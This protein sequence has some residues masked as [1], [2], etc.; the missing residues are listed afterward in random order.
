[1]KL[2]DLNYGENYK[3]EIDLKRSLENKIAGK[4]DISKS[5]VLLNYG[6]NSNLI[7]FFSS[8]AAKTLFEKK[9]RLKVLLDVPN[10]F[11][12]MTQLSQWPIKSIHIKRDRDFNFLFDKY[13]TAVKKHKP[14]VVVITTPNNPTGKPI[15]DDEIIKII[16]AAP[17]ESIVFID[18]SCINTLPELSSKDILH[19]Y[20]DKN[21]VIIHSFSKSHSLSDQRVGY[22]AS[23]R[24]EL[25]RSLRPKS[26][27][28][29]NLHGLQQLAKV[30]DNKK[31]VES[32]RKIITGCNKL[33]KKSFTGIPDF[34]YYESH[35]NFALIKLPAGI[36]SEYVEEYMKK[37]NILLMGGHRLGLG[38]SYIRIHMSGVDKIG[39]FI[40]EYER[41]IKL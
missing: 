16:K 12:T 41:M 14:D 11:F 35:S 7:L 20:P 6:S 3:E 34:T 4:L 18:R 37:K 22:L 39:K 13:I 15:K 26:D 10:Y 40:E 30:M 9:R 28:N 1:M 19:N 27:L 21:I 29:H 23:N 38:D 8:L 31:L 25:V 5:Q 17:K 33:L 32:K 2:I 36:T 24:V